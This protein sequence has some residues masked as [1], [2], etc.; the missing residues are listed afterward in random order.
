MRKMGRGAQISR[1]VTRTRSWPGQHVI[2]R[3]PWRPAC[4]RSGSVGGGC[5][6][7]AHPT[8]CQAHFWP[9]TRPK[10]AANGCCQHPQA[11]DHN[12]LTKS[13]PWPR[14]SNRPATT[15]RRITVGTSHYPALHGREY[16]VIATCR[17][18]GCVGTGCK[19]PGFRPT[20]VSVC[21]YPMGVWS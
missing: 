18:P 3:S 4:R 16:G 13:G 1:L 11:A 7:R 6:R 17:T 5:R 15:E 10:S 14:P 8:H 21:A 19:G 2:G 12:P 9:R 20:D